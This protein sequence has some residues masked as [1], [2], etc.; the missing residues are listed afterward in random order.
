MYINRNIEKLL[1]K[2]LKLFP[3]VCILGP[4]QCGKT[5]LVKNIIK[6]IKKKV[7]Y[8]DLELN[9]DMEKLSD[10]QIYLEH[11]KNE[12][13][14]IDEVQRLPDVVPLIRALVDQLSRPGRFILTGSADP[15][16]IKYTSESLAGRVAYIYLSTFNLTEIK[17]MSSVQK[18]WLRG[19]YPKSFLTG[20]DPN[21]FDWIDSYI[22]SFI[23]RDLILLG[24]DVSPVKMRR[25][26]TMIAHYNGKILNYSEFARNLDLSVVTIQRYFDFLEGAFLITRLYPFYA[27]LKKR[28]VKSPKIYIRDSGIL[29]GLL[30]I[31]NY[32]DLQNSPYVGYSWEGY[33]V[34]QVR[35]LIKKNI[36][37]Y[38]YRTQDGAEIDMVFCKS[39]NPDFTAEIKY[40]SAPKLNKGV[41]IAIND[42]KAKKNFIVIPE[43]D[44]YIKDKNITVCSLLTF[45]T[46]SFT[47]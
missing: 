17:S 27:N 21:A 40:S 2:Q 26:W 34:E 33:A 11:R 25:L 6:S 10:A 8:L 36:Q 47:N 24:L 5:T 4:R 15:S 7:T 38:Y 19:G 1:V 46:N 30:N 12:C 43:G 31:R 22:T 29:H 14:I 45:L 35:Q 18:H 32:N 37:F 16:L 3:V 9:T 20:S 41:E 13:V 42:L 44:E 23:E 28:L 39:V